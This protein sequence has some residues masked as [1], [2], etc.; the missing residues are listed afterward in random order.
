MHNAVLPSVLFQNFVDQI[1]RQ[2]LCLPG[3]SDCFCHFLWVWNAESFSDVVVQTLRGVWLFGTPWMVTRQAP[4]P[5]NFP[6]KNSEWVAISFSRGSFWPRDLGLLHRQVDSLPLSHWE[7]PVFQI[8]ELNF[9]RPWDKGLCIP[10]VIAR[11]LLACPIPITIHL[12]FCHTDLQC[13]RC[14][15][16]RES[17]GTS[18]KLGFSALPE[19]GGVVV[20]VLSEGLDLRTCETQHTFPPMIWPDLGHPTHPQLAL[21]AL[22]GA[23]GVFLLT[24]QPAASQGWWGRS[25]VP[26]DSDEMLIKMFS[27]KGG[28]E[29]STSVNYY[30]LITGIMYW[31]LTVCQPRDKF[32]LHPSSNSSWW[33]LLYPFSR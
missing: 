15:S 16:L 30:S 24:T 5:W 11:G 3:L 26:V 20:P 4:R 28:V 2:D 23:G 8:L 27:P 13:G 6:G 21:P 1:P 22:Q 10:L 7:S 12:V 33:L 14:P 17:G 19:A 32:S 29:R 9:K 25:Q 18:P 31:A